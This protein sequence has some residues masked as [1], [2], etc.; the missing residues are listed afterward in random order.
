ME[1]SARTCRSRLRHGVAT[2]VAG[3]RQGHDL[4]AH[5]LAQ[6]YEAAE[7]VVRTQ[8]LGDD[9]QVIAVGLGP[10]GGQVPA[11]VV[12]EEHDEALAAVQGGVDVLAEAADVGAA[13]ELRWLQVRGAERLYVGAR[14]A[15]HGPP[16]RGLQLRRGHEVR[17]QLPSRAGDQRV[18]ELTCCSREAV[19]DRL[20]EAAQQAP[21]E[22]VGHAG[23]ALD[24][25]VGSA[26]GGRRSAAP[27]LRSNGW[28]GKSVPR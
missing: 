19:G 14:H 6:A 21:G 28:S 8:H 3:A 7:E 1:L 12:G 2:L 10:A 24:P 17:A 15:A 4:Q 5:R 23:Q 26:A 9:A 20:R 27:G 11:A 16:R 18:H 22:A 13:V 25:A